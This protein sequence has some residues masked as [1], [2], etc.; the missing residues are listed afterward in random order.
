MTG[1]ADAARFGVHRVA[2]GQRGSVGRVSGG[3]AIGIFLK[4]RGLILPHRAW[5]GGCEGR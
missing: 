2:R 3:F 1:V 4:G 5:Y